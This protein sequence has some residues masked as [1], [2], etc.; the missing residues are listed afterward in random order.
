MQRCCASRSPSSS[1]RARQA[2]RSSPH[3][4]PRRHRLCRWRC[5]H[6]PARARSASS[7]N[8]RAPRSRLPGRRPRRPTVRPG[9]ATGCDDPRRCRVALHRA[10]GHA[11]RHRHG[12]GAGGPGV[13][14]GQTSSRIRLCQQALD[15]TEGAGARWHRR[16][17]RGSA[18]VPGALRLAWRCRW[19]AA[20][21]HARTV[22]RAGAGTAVAARRR[23]WRD[24]RPEASP[25]LDSRM[26]PCSPRSH[27]S[28]R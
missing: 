25:L 11:R 13:R 17:A 24:P 20:V 2:R 1:A 19:R 21:S 15:P 28:C 6:R 4:S 12:A 26:A 9:C 8:G 14:C 18:L 27:T 3:R 22:G 5:R 7:C 10:H 23:G 16:M